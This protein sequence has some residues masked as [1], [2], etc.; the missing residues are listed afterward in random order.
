MVGISKFKYSASR[1]WRCKKKQWNGNGGQRPSALSKKGRILHVAFNFTVCPLVQARYAQNEGTPSAPGWVDAATKDVAGGK[2]TREGWQCR[3]I[4]AA[5]RTA[6]MNSA[7]LEKR[8]NK[9][10]QR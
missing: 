5:P 4:C 7:L 2:A 6:R 3:S 10:V 9:E 1:T 8:K